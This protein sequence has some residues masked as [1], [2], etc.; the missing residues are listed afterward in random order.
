MILDEFKDITSD[1][2]QKGW[3]EMNGGNISYRLR[4]EELEN[5]DLSPE[6]WVNLEDSFSSIAGEYFLVTGSGRYFQNVRK[7]VLTNSGI[8]EVSSDGKSYRVVW[9]LHN[10]KPTSEL[11]THLLNHNKLCSI[12]DEYRV[13]LHVHPINLIILSAIFESDIELTKELWKVMTECLVIF[14][15]GI[16]LIEWM[17]P[18]SYEI[19][20]LSAN[21]ICDYEMVLWKNHGAFVKGKS[22]DH[23]FGMMDTIEKSASIYVELLKLNRK[24]NLITED[25]L[26]LLASDFGIKV[27]SRYDL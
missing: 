25:N 3:N 5:F 12:N 15:N 21:A 6:G 14:P 27:N 18:G 26:K 1:C 17:V 22:F 4:K 24:N 20:K 7:D 16:K 9:G 2:F 23:A 11:P 8:I 10:S 19:G 13:I